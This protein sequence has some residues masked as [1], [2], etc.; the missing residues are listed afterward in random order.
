[1]TETCYPERLLWIDHVP[2]RVCCSRESHWWTIP[3]P[4]VVAPKEP[5]AG[6]R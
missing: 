3:E 4:E 1:M 5:K 2:H 6:A